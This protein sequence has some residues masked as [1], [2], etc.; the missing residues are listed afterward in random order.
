MKN[1]IKLLSG[2]LLLTFFLLSCKKEENK[3]LFEGGSNPVLQASVTTPDLP[4]TYLNRDKEAIN[5]SWTNPDYKFNTGNSSQ[6]VSYQIEIDTSGANFTNPNK[7][8]VSV[9]K[10]LSKS[11]GVSELNGFLLNQLQLKKDSPHDIEIRVK[12]AL[13]NNAVVLYSNVLK[14]TVV[15]YSIP[16][17]VAAPVTGSLYL[18]GDATGGGWDNPVPVPTQQFTKIDDLHFELTVPLTGG[19]EYLFL[20]LNGDWG[21][22]FACKIKKEQSTAGG[23][24]GYDF[25]DNFPGPAASGNYKIVVDFQ[26]G[27]Y[28]VTK[29]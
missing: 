8:T 18:V 16:P 21:H 6:D 7:Q 11:F 2:P 28:S 15:P 17:I 10:D 1:L 13:A 26:R 3:V 25:N 12:S 19:K 27:K 5:L 14:Y 23:D 29:L 20:P 9:S 24:F 4:L 22:K